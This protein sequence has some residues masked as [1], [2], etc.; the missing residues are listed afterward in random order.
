[1]TREEKLEKI[2]HFTPDILIE[3]YHYF[4]EHFNPADFDDDT[5][6]IVKNEIKERLER[7]W[8]ATNNLR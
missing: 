2:K 5:L 1:M 3:A 8:K 7:D 4:Y 6:D